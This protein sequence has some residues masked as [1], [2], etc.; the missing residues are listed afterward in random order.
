MGSGRFGRAGRVALATSLAVSL[1]PVSQAIAQPEQQGLGQVGSTELEPYAS[2]DTPLGVW[3]EFGTCEWSVDDSYCLVIR[4]SNGAQ[5]GTLAAWGS[6]YDAKVAPWYRY[7]KVI[8]SARF[9]GTVKAT[10]ANGMFSYAAALETVD[11]NGLDTSEVTDFSGFLANCPS[12]TSV[13]L[14]MLDFSNAEKITTMFS[15]SASLKSINMSGISAPKVTSMF[16]M[17][18]MLDNLESVDLSGFKAPQLTDLSAMFSMCGQLKQVDLSGL[19]TSHVTSMEQMFNRCS[20]IET[21]DLSGF[22]T[23]NVTNMRMMFARCES[24]KNVNLSS[25][26]TSKVQTF[27]RMFQLCTSLET[28]DVS[29]F[30]TSGAE[31]LYCMFQACDALKSVDVSHFDTSNVQYFGGMFHRCGSLTSLDVSHFDTSKGVSFT[32]MFNGCAGLKTLDVSH[33][34][35]S[36]AKEL[37]SVFKNCTSL[38]SL[39]LSSFDTSAAEDTDYFLLGCDSLRAITVGPK[40]AIA[41]FPNPAGDPDGKWVDAQTGVEYSAS[42]VPANKAATYN[43]KV[44]INANMFQLEA[45]EFT[46]TGS[47]IKPKVSSSLP[48]GSYSV[49]YDNNV[50]AG[51]AVVRI[52][53]TGANSGT[54]E[55]PFTISPADIAAAD[56]EVSQLLT[57]EPSSPTTKLTFNGKTLQEGVDYRVSYE[58][59]DVPGPAVATIEGLGNFSGTLTKDFTVEKDVVYRLAGE[60]AADTAALIARAAVQGGSSEC[61]VIARDDDFADAM[62]ATGLAGQLN[63][64]I[65]LTNRYSLS[66]V[67]ADAIQRIGVKKAYVIGGT[68]AIPADLESQLKE[69]GCTVEKRVFGEEAC[70]TSVACAQ[71]I[72]ALGGSCDFAVIAYGQNFQDALS[73]S[74]FAYAHKAPIFLQTNGDTS[75]DRHLTDGA[76]S[77]LTGSG[78][79][80]DARVFVAGGHGAVSEESAEGALGGLRGGARLAGETGYDTSNQIAHYMVENGLL[81]AANPCVANGAPDPKGLDALAGAALAGKA[82]SVMLLTNPRADLG[83][84]ENSCTVKDTD[85]NGGVAFLTKYAGDVRDVAILGGTYVMPASVSSEIKDVLR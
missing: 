34:N 56:V 3:Y 57:D 35:T 43:A 22:D 21:I 62:S 19:D 68:G 50:D 37:A 7:N 20:S 54:C 8:K 53:G 23:S 29:G 73:M 81:S 25:F 48:E 52:T 15:G 84:S 49:T 71:E 39:D 51:T 47:A 80:A 67:A 32:G 30:D 76:L 16:S 45:D 24:L 31:S 27:E 11:L 33:F 72:K 66:P 65:V 13:D 82:G 36:S 60:E 40:F 44:N 83:D 6:D 74:S 18:S 63:A 46:Y 69:V 12:L 26:N 75:K 77:L 59:G 64:P 2:S 38:E 42:E 4:P 61:V 5:S 79:Y 78:V 55:I 9:E 14:S 10:V 28:V 1:C 41:E 70:D 58:G 17:F 85:S